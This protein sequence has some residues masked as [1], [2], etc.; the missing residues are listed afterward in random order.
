M[1]T[2]M[3]S[4]AIFVAFLFIGSSVAASLVGNN[5][6]IENNNEVIEKATVKTAARAGVTILTNFVETAPQIIRGDTFYAYNAYDPSGTLVEG[7]VYFDSDI[8]GTITQLAPTT[9][10]DFIAGGTWDGDAGLW[11]GSE[12]GSG[13]FY[14]IDET[15]GT[16]TLIGSSTNDFSGLAYDDSTGTLYG[17]S[18]TALYTIDP[19]TGTDTLVGSYGIGGELMIAIACDN[20]G[21]LYGHD[22]VT[23]SIY[24]IDSATG[25]ATL[26][27]LTGLSCNY[28]QGMEYDKVNDVLYLSAYTSTGELYTCDT[29]T[30]TCTFVGTFQGGAE[31]TG[32]A[33]PYTSGPMPDH[34]LALKSIIEP[35]T[36]TGSVITPEVTIQNKGLNDEYSIPVTME[37]SYKVVTGVDEGFEGTFPPAGWTEVVYGGATGNWAQGTYGSHSYEP[38]GTGSHYLDA[39]DGDGTYSWNNEFFTP[40][41]DLTGVTTATMIFERNFQDFAGSGQGTVNTYSGSNMTFEEELLYLTSDDPSGGVHTELS[42]DPTNYT[43]PSEV[44]IGFWYTDDDYGSAWG[45][46]IDDVFMGYITWIL[47]YTDT[48]Y[49][50]V[51]FN[52]TITATFADWTPVDLGLVE[53]VDV[54]YFVEA[55]IIFA[56]NNTGNNYKDKE[57]SLH[58]G[59]F[60]DIGVNGV[61]SPESMMAEAQAPEVEVENF[62]QND[63]TGVGINV[64]IQALDT[65]LSEDF[66]GGVPPAGWQTTHSSN[67]GSSST[68]Y[69]GGVAPEAK[70]SWSPSSVDTFRLYTDPIDTTGYTDVMLS[71]KE[72]VNDFNGLYDLYVETSTDGSN[73]TA[74]Y[75]RP[76]GPY[77]PATTSVLLNASL[78]MGSAT[79]QLS[80]T[81]V[82]DSYNINYWYIDDVKILNPGSTLEYD[83]T[84]TIDIASGEVQNV[85]FPI[86]TP[87]DLI[88]TS[89]DYIVTATASVYSTGAPFFSEGFEGFVSGVPVIPPIG[90]AIYNNDGGSYEWAFST[91]GQYAGSGC[92][93]CRYETGGIVN[94]DWIVTKGTTV[95]SGLNFS[96]WID[97]YSYGDD[98]FK[99]WMSTTGNTISD[100]LSGT[101]LLDETS[102]PASYTFYEFDMSSYVGQTVYFAIQ[103]TGDY[104]WYIWADDFT[105]PDGTFEGFEPTPSSGF[106]PTGWQNVVWSGTGV[107]EGF[108]YGSHSYEPAG[109]GED[110]AS[111]W[112][113]G[114]SDDYDVGLFTPA[115]DFTGIPVAQLSFER[116]FQDYSGNGDGGV[117]VYSGPGGMYYEE[118]LIY[119]TSDDPSAGVHTELMFVPSGYTDPSEVYFEFWYYRAGG[120]TAWGYSI[121]DVNMS[122]LVSGDGNPDNDQFVKMITLEYLH[123]VG[124]K[125]II[126]PY[127]PPAA[128]RDPWDQLAVFD[129]G[130]TGSSGAN[131]NAGAESDGTYLYSTRWSANLLHQYDFTGA[132]VKEFSIPGVTGLRDLAYNPN[133]GYF[134]GGAAGGTIWEMDFDSETL[135]STISGGF[136]SRAISYNE[137]DDVIYCSNWGDPVWV[138][139]PSSGA[140]LDT[141][142]L[143]TTTSTY[144]FA[145]DNDGTNKFLYVFDQTTGAESTVYQ[146]DLDAGAYTGFTYDMTP[147]VGSGAGIAGGLFI[148]DGFVPN[149]LVIGGCVQD[150]SL[151]GVTDWLA[152]YELRDESGGSAQEYLTPGIYP[153]T[154]TVE[155]HGT[156]TE[157][158]NVNAKVI[159]EDEK[160]DVLIYED[161][162]SVV[163]L[164][165]GAIAIV[166]FADVEFLEG[167]EWEGNYRVEITTQLAGDEVAGNDKKTKTFLM[168]AHDT[169]PPVTTHEFTGTMGEEDWYVSEVT[170]I[171]TAEDPAEAGDRW[172]SG[173]NNTYYSFDGTTYELYTEPITV[174]DDGEHELY[175]YSDDMAGNVEDVN[176]PFDFNIDATPPT[177]ELTAEG[178]GTTWTLTA[179]A[180]DATSGIAKVE[181]YVNDEF[182]GEDTSAP[183]EWEY[184]GASSGDIAQ[185]IAYDNAGNSKISDP[186][187]AASL[188]SQSNPIWQVVQQNNL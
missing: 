130:A 5:A 76:G 94:D 20:D 187:E 45:F 156:F 135:I 102:P 96:V 163:D 98:Y 8:P 175:Y 107:W 10:G 100:F 27:G 174:E 31:M 139:D 58:Y 21:N 119:F 23:D 134:Y 103:Y 181:F 177:I 113:N 30:G 24:S 184:T 19:T 154:A 155:N 91:S 147:E 57:F 109:S 26:I 148:T 62:G 126:E 129:I 50:N 81:F 52:E 136:Q 115:F 25:A 167:V 68:N 118:E 162:V 80:F 40:A 71:Y 67:W 106:P 65:V 32:F 84:V 43:D 170:I 168:H 117:Y 93:K 33:I 83:E 16:M 99:I 53:N 34:D 116:N 4:T 143:V 124:T 11:Y 141:I 95:A 132:L 149:K 169:I 74:A 70:F 183:Y 87:L 150:S 39:W 90:W 63:E 153:V 137:D 35:S 7:P 72:Y 186:V 2:T 110:Y 37:I 158:F 180:V 86:W 88:S 122:L 89:V 128:N 36:G 47:E 105:F 157:T 108:N 75:H 77:G 144:G 73:W 161:N 46:G 172:A 173:V 59:Y 166:E 111:A 182:L 104:A 82:G 18:T 78:G 41:T 151:P 79:F 131:G 64:Q 159:F 125:E 133:T 22:I 61:P 142:N 120:T 29:T 165:Y 44:Y 92:V 101:L 42:F 51:M 171:L 114:N 15:D 6:T 97:T 14:T 3:L 146:W 152:I 69:A 123:D 85:V 55:E 48:I 60:H 176:G 54:E 160:D 12:Y 17:G 140:I 38:A 138:V 121:D 13:D 145:Y 112:A 28:A 127:Y 164:G 185:A 56:D 178:S 179:D 66:S 9:S 1:K 188:Q 49:V